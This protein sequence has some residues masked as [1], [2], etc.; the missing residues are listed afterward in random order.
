MVVDMPGAV[1]S[2]LGCVQNYT[3]DECS[4]LSW[5]LWYR[6]DDCGDT[7]LDVAGLRLVEVGGDSGM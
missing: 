5:W 2:Y 3:I 4:G 7:Q 6:S 1:I